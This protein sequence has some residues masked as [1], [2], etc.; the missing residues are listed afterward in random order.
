M[1]VDWT[2]LK[3]RRQGL[4]VQDMRMKKVKE[5]TALQ[6]RKIPNLMMEMTLEKEMIEMTTTTMKD[7]TKMEA[8]VATVVLALVVEVD[9]IVAE[10][11]CGLQLALWH[12][13]ALGEC[14]FREN[15]PEHQEA[16][17]QGSTWILRC[18]TNVEMLLL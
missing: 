12:R 14:R 8:L 18:Y 4:E 5:K 7:L 11:P 9:L 10:S 2:S 6:M 16:K 13:E 15:V 17:Q 3:S 1:I